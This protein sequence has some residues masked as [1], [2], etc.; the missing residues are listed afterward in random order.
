MTNAEAHEALNQLTQSQNGANRLKALI[1][2]KHFVR[3][4][5]AHSIAFKFGCCRKANYFKI[6]LN[7]WDLYDL[8]FGKV[9]KFDYDVVKTYSGV[10]DDMLKDIF[11][12]FTGLTLSLG[13]I[14]RS[15]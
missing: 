1:G 8:E 5:K 2:A 15:A 3:D 13:E 6:T 4:E 9:K 12:E 10:Y 11:E 14:I 7:V